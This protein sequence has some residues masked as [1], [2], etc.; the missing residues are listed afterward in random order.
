MDN[1]HFIGIW[2]FYPAINRSI[3]NSQPQ[4]IAGFDLLCFLQNFS[5]GSVG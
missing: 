1:P 2:F 5:G 3:L 4:I